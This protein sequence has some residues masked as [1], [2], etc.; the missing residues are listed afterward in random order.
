LKK[1][2]FGLLI[3]TSFGWISARAQEL[4]RPTPPPAA[5]ARPGVPEPPDDASLL[6][7]FM[8]KEDLGVLA[9]LE[10]HPLADGRGI[11]VAILDTGV[12][13]AHP[14]LQKTSTG[15]PKIVDV[16][17]GTDD[18]YLPL[19]VKATAGGAALRGLSGRPLKL[20]GD[21]AAGAEVRLGLIVDRDNFPRGLAGR[22]HA[23]RQ[24]AW[25]RERERWE[26][27]VVDSSGA[28]T[29]AL[30]AAFDSLIEEDDDPGD[31]FDVIACKRDKGWEVR[32]D[33]DADGDLAEET[34]L[35]PFR[36]AQQIAF[37]P[38]PAHLAVALERIAPDGSSIFLFHDQGGHGSHV[39]GIV[40]GYYGP[41]D[42][43]NG[44]APGAQLLACKVGNGRMG[45]GTSHNSIMKCAQWAVDHGADVINISFG[46]DTFFEDGNED[47]ARFLDE[48]VEKTG[49][50]I[51]T[52]A[53]NEGPALSTI[54]APGT[55]KRI[56]S[57]G[58]AISK[59]TQQTNYSSLEPRRDDMFQFSSR[60]PL[61]DGDPGID[62]ISPGV[63]LSTLPSWM[64]VK[65]ESWNGTS[66]ASPQGAGFCALILSGCRQEG[67]PVTPDRLRRAMRSGA[68]RLDG[69]SVI[70]Q[71]GGIPQ[72]APTLD[73]CADLATAYPTK[74]TTGRA[75]HDRGAA[76]PVVGYI[77]RV[78]NATGT[79]GGYYER[80]LRETAPYRVNF[81]VRPDFPSDS[82]QSARGDFLRIVKLVSE[83][84][85]MQPPPQVS[86]AA[87]GAGIPVRIDPALLQPGLNVGRVV[88]RDVAHPDAGTEFELVA[89]VI[90][91][92]DVDPRRPVAEGTLDFTRGDR[93]SVFFRVP[94]GA[95][96]A[97]LTVRETLA[98]PANGYEIAVSAQDLVRP[99]GE[100]GTESRFVL[101]A[102]QEGRLDVGVLSRDV[103][104][105][106][107]FSR[108]HDNRPGRLTYRIE[109]AGVSV[110][111]EP[112]LRVEAG[113]P[114]VGAVVTAPSWASSVSLEASLDRKVT[115][116]DVEWRVRPDTLVDFPLNGI[117]SMVQEGSAYLSAN[118]GETVEFDLRLPP[119]FE[120]PLDDAFFRVYDD[121]DRTVA[122]GYFDI[123]RMSFTAP[124]AGTYRIVLSIYARGRRMFD[125][126][127]PLVS[128]VRLSSTG[129]FAATIFRDP[130][131]G[132][133]SG[134]DSL[135]STWLAG[136]EKRRFFLRF[137]DLG[138]GR[139]LR[140]ALRIKSGD[141]LLA[142]V[143]IEADM[144]PLE[145]GVDAAIGGIVE[146]ALERARTMAG[147][148]RVDGKARREALEALD[149]AEALRSATPKIESDDNEGEEEA[150][151][152]AV[153][154]NELWDLAEARLHLLLQGEDMSA[155]E[156]AFAKLG[157]SMP[158][159]DAKDGRRIADR[160]GKQALLEELA[161][162]IAWK[163]GDAAQARKRFDASRLLN[164][165]VPRT[166]RLEV[167]LL[168][169]EEENADLRAKAADWLREHP[170]DAEV[171]AILTRA[172]A[173]E[174]W[175]DLAAMRLAAWPRLHPQAEAQLQSLWGDVVAAREKAPRAGTPFGAFA[176]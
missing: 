167:L 107:I 42:P 131:N 91:P 26:A 30:R 11:V 141:Q 166:Q 162:E 157:E 129:P 74:V 158:E 105:L 148:S 18:G 47:T 144:R 54:G 83:S 77:V 156:R 32:I 115:P 45:G 34:A 123:P 93:R 27:A 48:L 52:S 111:R 142:T 122:K 2:I 22:R 23:E 96:V 4:P 7:G 21:L 163:K 75:A 126:A 3:L 164:P 106:A 149:R 114:G 172:L 118:E 8:P 65:S 94:D 150:E 125:Y 1:W 161:G 139:M 10:A 49:V 136:G 29:D 97:R 24:E 124:R 82:L 133:T 16:Y 160:R 35:R 170:D 78:A 135:D 154:P 51:C 102:G 36:E 175:W 88:A 104:E 171:D 85:W 68:R 57:W 130:V 101:A 92:E 155:I 62:F 108:W 69:I 87:S 103:L 17:D 119:E 5:P 41:D 89:T 90:R 14:A 128:P 146:T 59:K 176:P 110:V 50:I 169:V 76:R 60:G 132:F 20:P 44:L 25:R 112:P 174:G 13:L 80:D 173:R 61:L 116:L 40:A 38:D 63:A 127:R 55:A 99:P 6:Q 37:F 19:P 67:I 147:L 165:D 9:F 33:T 66:M 145:A 79:G 95:T 39:A 153:P 121:S 100:R 43:L 70:E 86:I 143:P 58:A 117:P 140:G 152:G 81:G 12:D 134:P 109:F 137:E 28:R 73:A 72:A 113:R 98:N 46:G 138:E 168:S 15:E 64:L 84:P 31:R 159:E 151:E 56:F 71:G 53:G 120:D